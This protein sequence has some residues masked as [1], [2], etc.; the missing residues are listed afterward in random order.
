MS[1]L[2]GSGSTMCLGMM[3]CHPL[4]KTDNT[5]GD[6]P[7]PLITIVFSSGVSTL[8]IRD[9]RVSLRGLTM[10]SG[11]NII[12]SMVYLTSSEEKGAPS[13]HFTFSAKWKVIVAPSSAISQEVAKSGM[14]SSAKGS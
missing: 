10:P 5:N 3:P 9:L 11:G 13:C 2:T 4:E 14:S 7:L 1:A 12:R 6:G 8:S